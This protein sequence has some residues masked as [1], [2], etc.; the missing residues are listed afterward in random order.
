MTKRK[1]FSCEADLKS[2]EEELA[3]NK[4]LASLKAKYTKEQLIAKKLAFKVNLLFSISEFLLSRY[5]VSGQFSCSRDEK[6]QQQ[7]K[8]L[9]RKIGTF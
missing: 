1:L 3:K 7:N 4:N 9:S 6:L 2:R 5:N 8:L